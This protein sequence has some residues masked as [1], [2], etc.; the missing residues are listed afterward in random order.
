MT[1]T[2]KTPAAKAAPEKASKDGVGGTIR[3]FAEALIIALI[4]RTFLF[5]PFEIPSGSLIPT[6]E[7]GDYLFVS[8]YSYG[9]SRYSFP[10]AIAP[11]SGRIFGS[12]PDQGDIAV[13][14][15]PVD[16]SKDY[17]KRVIGLPGDTVQMKDGRLYINDKIVER[18]PIEP[19][20]TRNGF[21]EM[22]AVPQYIETLP[23][24]VKHRI[25][26]IQGDHGDLD[27]TPRFEVP[28]D[29]VFMMGDNRDNSA[30]SR[31][32]SEMGYVPVE[33][34]EGKAQMIFL[35][36]DDRSSLWKFWDW[37]WSIRWSRMFTLV[38]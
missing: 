22:V 10:F 37:P 14:R 29:H 23:N 1:D 18:E 32:P 35:S 21:G 7:I 15:G 6:L 25:I 19:F 5:Q 8:K 34:L 24:G 17:I 30:D 2:D 31:V 38:R 28:P 3:V 16:Q 36:V 11:I 26:E 12:L 13:F 27:N 4:V 33:N 9:Y 20:E